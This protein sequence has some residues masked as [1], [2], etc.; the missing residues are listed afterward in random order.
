M[1]DND[2]ILDV[3]TYAMSKAAEVA[4]AAGAVPVWD[5]RTGQNYAEW[6]GDGGTCK[7]WLE[8]VQSLKAK[9][10]VMK[11][12]DIG[13]AAVWQLAFGTDEAFALVNGYYA[14]PA[15]AVTEE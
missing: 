15:P 11:S 6:K 14:A 3:Q 5:D 4:S 8:D 10:D 2:K 1:D 9:L 13:G 7:M 12:H